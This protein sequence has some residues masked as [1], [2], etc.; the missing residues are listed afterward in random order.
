VDRPQSSTDYCIRVC[1]CAHVCACA[2]SLPQADAIVLEGGYVLFLV[3]RGDNTVPIYKKEFS[4][5][6]NRCLELL[7]KLLLPGHEGYWDNLY[8][9]REVSQEVAKGGTY[10]ADI[11]AG[12][13]AGEKSTITVPPTGT[14][15]TARANRG[16]DPSCKQPNPKTDK[17]SKAKIDE[18]KAKPIE[19]RVKSS[20][21]VSEPRVLCVSVFDNGPVHMLDTIH[22]SAGIITILKP[23]WDATSKKK[24]KIPLRILAI[25]DEYNHGVGWTS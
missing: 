19:E 23:R 3:F 21:S 8:P 4:P 10:T 17:L 1:V 11:P 6:H 7:S 2:A 25:I 20:M 9:S 13:R 15:G 14:S 18:I 12:P 22:T 5:L 24:V 16:I